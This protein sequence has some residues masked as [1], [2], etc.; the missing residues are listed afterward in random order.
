MKKLSYLITTFVF[1]TLGTIGVNAASISN[2][3]LNCPSNIGTGERTTC[4][5][6]GDV[7][8]DMTIS[9]VELS[10][11]ITASGQ[12]KTVEQGTIKI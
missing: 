5:V 3:K 7:D 2:V 11:D 1:A 8:E 9:R 6:V 10:G 4:T 12:G